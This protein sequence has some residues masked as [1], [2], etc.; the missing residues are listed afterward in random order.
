M[1]CQ[2]FK[3]C[4]LSKNVLHLSAL[5]HIPHVPVYSKT[6]QESSL[7][8]RVCTIKMGKG[9]LILAKYPPPPPPRFFAL[10]KAKKKR[11]ECAPPL[12]EILDPSLVCK[13]KSYS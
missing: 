6:L 1:L 11:K 5:R 4:I 8:R 12:S 13:Q 3:T 9:V 10:I 7:R 2:H